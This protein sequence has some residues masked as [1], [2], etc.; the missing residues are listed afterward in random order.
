MC[1]NGLFATVAESGNFVIWDVEERRITFLQQ[2]KGIYQLLLHTS[3]TMVIVVSS[4]AIIPPAQA[5]Q[6]GVNPN[7]TPTGYA[8]RAVSFAIP[9]GDMNYQ[10]SFNIKRMT[11]PKK[12]ICTA[13][14]NYLIFIEEK[15]NNDV[16][17]LYDPITG[18]HLH[19]V[20][21][22]YNG[23]KDI[24]SMVTIPKQ[25]HLIGLIDA[26]K[27]V[28]MNVRDKKV[29]EINETIRIVVDGLFV[30]S[31]SIT[32]MEWTNFIG[33]KIWLICTNTWWS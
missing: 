5:S 14:D 28:V 4:E 19:N 21:L 31:F 27:G 33:W 18:D 26:D 22:T 30:G 2:I 12:A 10:I 29:E 16:L 24:L 7:I 23:Y 25:P 20:K 1:A 32:E 15:K 3:D 11:Q 9:D 13:D 6:F 8:V 17:S